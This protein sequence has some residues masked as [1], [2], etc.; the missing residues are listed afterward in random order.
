MGYYIN[1]PGESKETFLNNK[2]VKLIEPP[3]F[4]KIASDMLPVCL[5][6]NGLFTAAGIAYSQ[7]ELATFADTNDPR[8]RQWYL[9]KIKDLLLVSDLREE[10]IQR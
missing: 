3:T 5:V 7:K 1:P 2:G 4:D 9:V 8:P 6:D 10:F